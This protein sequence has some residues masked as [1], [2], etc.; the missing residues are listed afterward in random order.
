MISENTREGAAASADRDGV[1]CPEM[2][3]TDAASYSDIVFGLLT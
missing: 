1:P 3:V 2:I